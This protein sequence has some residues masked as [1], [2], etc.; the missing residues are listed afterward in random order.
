MIDNPADL[1]QPRGETPAYTA[2]R[3][4]AIDK[5]RKGENPS[6]SYPADGTNSYDSS[7]LSD[8]GK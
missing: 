2:R 6:G 3:T 5:Y 4:V 1:V 7:K 8:L